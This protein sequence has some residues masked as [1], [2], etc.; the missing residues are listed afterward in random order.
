[1]I[2]KS[3]TVASHLVRSLRF[4][5]AVIAI[6]LLAASSPAF[7]HNLPLLFNGYYAVTNSV[8]VDPANPAYL[9]IRVGGGGGASQLGKFSISTTDQRLVF[10]T[11]V[12]TGTINMEDSDGNKLIGIYSGPSAQ[13]P[14][15]RFTFG[16]EIVFNGGTG[17]Y[18]KASGSV[19]V[20]GWARV[21]P[22]TSTGIG[23]VTFK[24]WLRG[25]EV[26]PSKY[27]S[28]V[29]SFDGRVSNPN[30][31]AVGKGFATRIGKFRDENATIASPIAGFVGLVD[32]KFTAL[33]PF[34]SV[35]TTPGGDQL[36]LTSVETV[37]FVTILLPDGTPV[38]DITQP[39]RAKLYQTIVGGTGRFAG[40]E[41]VVF[42]NALFTPT[43]TDE[44]GALVIDGRHCGSGALVSRR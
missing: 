33:Y 34:D 18:A 16:G 2:I 27:F 3:K 44:N 6:Q 17:P 39:S 37:S 24:G 1:M 35:W 9:Q 30:F 26:K 28:L 4:I 41:G 13:Q 5:A 36:F 15:G 40:T 29:E 11:G 32:G 20:D 43:G 8:F 23:L 10:A 19:Q 22:E 25:A 42:G 31:T 12:Q 7:A 21:N 38:P 14:D